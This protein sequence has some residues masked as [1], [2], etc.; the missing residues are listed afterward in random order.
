MIPINLYVQI[1][2]GALLIIMVNVLNAKKDAHLV[3]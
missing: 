2:I 3:K 1:A